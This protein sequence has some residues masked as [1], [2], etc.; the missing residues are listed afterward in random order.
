MAMA[1]PAFTLNFRKR[2]DLRLGAT[3]DPRFSISQDK[4][5]L[6]L[7][8]RIKTSLGCGP[9]L[10]DE[11]RI[12]WIPVYGLSTIRENC[13]ILHRESIVWCESS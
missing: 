1:V 8:E 3:C 4:R 2:P 7:L 10:P 11:L 13:S 12:V 6:F 9:F 5:D